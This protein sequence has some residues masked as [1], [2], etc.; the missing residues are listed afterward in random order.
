MKNLIDALFLPAY[1][2]H[3][4]IL[5]RPLLICSVILV[6]TLA[7]LSLPIIQELIRKSFFTVSEMNAIA[8]EK[9]V[10]K[11]WLESTSFIL[12]LLVALLI[13]GS[14]FGEQLTKSFKNAV[15]QYE[16]AREV[17]HSKKVNNLRSDLEEAIK[18]SKAKIEQ[19]RTGSKADRIKHFLEVIREL[20]KIYKI[21]FTDLPDF[22][23]GYMRFVLYANFPGGLYG[24]LAFCL[25]FVSATLKLVTM[26]LGSPYFQ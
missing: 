20:K 9:D 5:S 6:C 22:Y 25:F 26:Y 7:I 15:I 23:K 24:V 12:D 16:K 2:D 10:L 13:G 17:Y 18:D 8:A 19:Y 11:S 1:T 3:R 14:V 4:K 21:G